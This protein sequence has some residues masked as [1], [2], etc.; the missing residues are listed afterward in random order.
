MVQISKRKVKPEVMDR[1]F[2]LLFTVIGSQGGEDKF[3]IIIN[4]LFSP[5]EKIVVAKRI[6]ILL[7]IL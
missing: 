1:M 6:A 7:L 4:G 5:V 3:S 2:K